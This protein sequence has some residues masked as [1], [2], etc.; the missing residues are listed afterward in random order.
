MQFPVEEHLILKVYLNKD[1]V[2]YQDHVQTLDYQI[3]G[4]SD[5]DQILSH[6]F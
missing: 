6:D 1:N 3:R 2:V 5:N 4:I